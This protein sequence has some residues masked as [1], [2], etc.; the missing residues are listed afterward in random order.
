MKKSVSHLLS[1][2]V[3]STQQKTV[4]P[5]SLLSKTTEAEQSCENPSEDKTVTDGLLD[6]RTLREKSRNMDLP[7][8]SALCNDRS[9]LKQTNAFVMPRHPTNDKKNGR[10]VSWHV[11]ST[12]KKVP[13]LKNIP[14]NNSVD[15]GSSDGTSKKGSLFSSF[16][17]PKSTSNPATPV[18]HSTYS[19]ISSSKLKYPVSGL[20][21]NQIVKPGRKMT[22]SRHTHPADN[23]VV[24]NQTKVGR[25]RS[26]SSTATSSANLQDTVLPR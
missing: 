11:E 6:I 7:L 16:L 9:L 1:T 24:V 12:S 22:T 20:S 10:P 17:S 23:K 2:A 21:T 13:D 26:T 3:A 8:I 19:T 14:T 5:V 25:S 4:S 18:K 15:S